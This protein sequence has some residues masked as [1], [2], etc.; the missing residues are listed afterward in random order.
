[1]K[2]FISKGILSVLVIS[3]VLMSG[4]TNAGTTT[5]NIATI[6]VTVTTPVPA[7]IPNLVGNWTGTAKGYS[8]GTGYKEFVT[9]PMYLIVTDQKDR[10]FTGHMIFPQNNGSVRTEG[11]SGVFSRE[12]KGFEIVEYTSGYCG[13]TIV[14][15]NEIEL[16]YADDSEPSRIMIDSL[17]RTR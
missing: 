6:P 3:M 2:N 14:S 17:T 10:F 13:G 16:I 5:P 8:E 7:G 11:F 9:N 4:C 1:M 12:G 15:A